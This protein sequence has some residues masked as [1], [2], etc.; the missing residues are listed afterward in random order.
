MP[1]L[2][3][4]FKNKYFQIVIAKLSLWAIRNMHIDQEKLSKYVRKGDI[5]CPAG[6][7]RVEGA[8]MVF[9]SCTGSWWMMARV[10]PSPGVL[11]RSSSFL[12]KGLVWCNLLF[13]WVSSTGHVNDLIFSITWKSTFF[14]DD[15]LKSPF[16]YPSYLGR[17]KPAFIFFYRLWKIS[18]AAFY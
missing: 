1:K 12:T 8:A 6:A 14:H 10:S 5:F 15:A 13:Q 9:S 17:F 11:G 3:K 4:K 16:F 18:P 2:L 7:F